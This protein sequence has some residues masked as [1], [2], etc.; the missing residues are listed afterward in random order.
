VRFA[1]CVAQFESSRPNC[2]RRNNVAFRGAKG[3][4]D[5]PPSRKLL[6]DKLLHDK[7]LHDKLL[8]DKLL[9]DNLLYHAIGL[10][11]LKEGDHVIDHA[12]IKQLDAFGRLVG[13]V[14]REH[15]LLAR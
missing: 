8:R 1:E 10:A 2:S 12:G 6:H 11:S 3:D 5:S 4:T 9:R 14:R 13:V 15:H 7:L